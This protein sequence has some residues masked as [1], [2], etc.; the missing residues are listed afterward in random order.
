MNAARML[1][2]RGDHPAAVE[3]LG[4]R[5]VWAWHPSRWPEG[6]GERLDALVRQ[7]GGTTPWVK[8]LRKGIGLD[9][10][11]AAE[12]HAL[13]VAMCRSAQRQEAARQV[14]TRARHAAASALPPLRVALLGCGKTKLPGTHR[15]RDLY[16]GPLFRASLAY[17]ERTAGAIF[18][19]SARYGLVELDE[20]IE[21]YDQTL[22]TR[23]KRERLSWGEAVAND[24]LRKLDGR[25]FEVEIL[26]GQDYARPIAHPLYLKSCHPASTVLAITKP[27]EG[28]QVGERLRWFRERAPKP[29]ARAETLPLP[30]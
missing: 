13:D 4:L 22:G 16:V 30:L 19:V 26:A 9:P 8:A 5:D 20:R 24:L 2:D 3:L 6:L 7:L 18:I 12:Q 29:A 23:P 15:A 21:C 11:T 14:E 28:L 1:R 10:L 17:A 27:L 25:R